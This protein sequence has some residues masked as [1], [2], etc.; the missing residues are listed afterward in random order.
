M[1]TLSVYC[2]VG[3]ETLIIIQIHL[4]FQCTPSP[5]Q[6]LILNNQLNPTPFHTGFVVGFVALGQ[7]SFRVLKVLLVGII[8]LNAEFSFLF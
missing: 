3:S 2:E 4:M 7:V 6:L 1:K 5:F 8:S